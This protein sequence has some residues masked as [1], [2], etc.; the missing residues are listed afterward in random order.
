MISNRTLFVLYIRGDTQIVLKGDP[1]CYNQ[2]LMS[3]ISILSQTDFPNML[4]FYNTSCFVN[5]RP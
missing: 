3:I 5:I 2:P 1:D 4:L